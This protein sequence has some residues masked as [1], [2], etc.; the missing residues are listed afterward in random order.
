MHTHTHTG[1]RQ[2][3]EE[4]DMRRGL[5]IDHGSNCNVFLGKHKG[6]SVAIKE[7]LLLQFSVA[8]D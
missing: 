7:V 2:L 6:L 4:K 3:L 8:V 1:S 5:K